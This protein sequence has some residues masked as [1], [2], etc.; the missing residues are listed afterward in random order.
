MFWKSNKQQHKE[1]HIDISEVTVTLKP[2][3][4]VAPGTYLTVLYGFILLALIFVIFFLPGIIAGGTYITFKTSPVQA[5]VWIDGKKVG[6]TPCEVLVKQ[7]TRNIELKRPFYKTVHMERKVG[8]FVFALPF[9]PRRESIHTDIAAADM[10]GLTSG[11]LADFAGWAMIK[12]F[13]ANY[14]LPPI[15]SEAAESI[16][17]ST[18]QADR[19]KLAAFLKQAVS[20][21]Q[22]PYLARELFLAYAILESGNSVFTQATLVKLAKDYLALSKQYQNLPFWIF[23]VLPVYAPTEIGKKPQP[24]TEIAREKGT[25][26][27]FL[28]SPWFKKIRKHY[29]DFL[30]AYRT[31]TKAALGPDRFI[32]GIH[33]VPVPGGEFVMGK[34]DENDVLADPTTL[35]LLPHPVA[36]NAF[37][38][39]ENEISNRQF[40]AFIDENPGWK[41]SQRDTLVAG[42]LADNQYLK[43]WQND[44]FPAGQGE[45]PVTHVSYFAAKAFCEWFTGK[46]EKS[47]PGLKARLPLESEWEWA[48]TGGIQGGAPARGSIF[49]KDTIQGPGRVG[50]SLPNRFGLRD[51][52]GNVWEWCENWYAPVSY[53]VTSYN[54]EVNT[55]A[56]A[57]ITNGALKVVRGGS[58]ANQQSELHFYTRGSQ[59][60]SWCT[61]FL[62]FRIVLV[63]R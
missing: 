60:P 20:Y 63:R 38:C 62:G 37:Y 10:D 33:F 4:N 25:K 55:A 51:M 17:G 24:E 3:G 12:D 32:S 34:N 43:D 31:R 18:D 7:G 8:G 30:A 44:T 21:T 5:G 23:N 57:G 50:S 9:L 29:N 6:V 45:L 14:Q 2:I 46:V 28:D 36:V 39:S 41:P 27:G 1:K 56:E 22:S 58:W 54:P 40:K 47:V 48:A 19:T 13:S 35:M 15:L 59:P 11:T 61:G 53:L 42:K 26:Y 52:A 49:F 16:R